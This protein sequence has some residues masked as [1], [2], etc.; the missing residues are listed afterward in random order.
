[1]LL[2]NNRIKADCPNLIALGVDKKIYRVK[3][4]VTNPPFTT[5]TGIKFLK[6]LPFMLYIFTFFKKYDRK[7]LNSVITIDAS[8]KSKDG[9]YLFKYFFGFKKYEYP[10]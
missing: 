2:L 6:A 1:L 8:L 4:K 10:G 7:E 9:A 5:L 3:L